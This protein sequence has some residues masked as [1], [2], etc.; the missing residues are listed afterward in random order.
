MDVEIGGVSAFTVLLGLLWH[1]KSLFHSGHD[2]SVACPKPT[3][4]IIMY[5][6]SFL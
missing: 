5:I 2:L 6:L 1:A 3:T 4:R